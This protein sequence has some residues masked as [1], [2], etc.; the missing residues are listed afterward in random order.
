MG[1]EHGWG[2]GRATCKGSAKE[3]MGE[4]MRTRHTATFCKLGKAGWFTKQAVE[5]LRVRGTCG[6]TSPRDSHPGDAGMA[7]PAP[8]PSA[9]H[10]S[11]A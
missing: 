3:G 7:D 6:S 10:P 4:G 1:V 11:A 2:G 5:I 8:P 9:L